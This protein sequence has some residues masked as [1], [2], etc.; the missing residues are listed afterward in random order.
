MNSMQQG[1]L[2][3]PDTVQICITDP[4]QP[5][6]LALMAESERYMSAL[7]PAESNHFESPEALTKSNVIFLGVFL[8]QRLIGCGAVKM[9]QDDGHYG[10]VKRVFIHTDFRGR[11]Y[12][13]QLMLALE[14]A[15]K[16][17]QVPLSRLETGIYQPE[18]LGLYEKLGYQYREPFA[19]YQTDPLSVFMEKIL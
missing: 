4:L 7:Y 2:N 19:G 17:Q 14:S 1:S 11:G 3:A 18:A 13:R 12:S 10:E 16:Q 8:Q 5:A 6:A 9:M 15:L